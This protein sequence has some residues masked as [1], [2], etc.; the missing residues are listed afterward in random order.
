MRSNRFKHLSRRQL[1][2]TS[3]AVLIS[4]AIEWPRMLSAQATTEELVL[5]NGRIHTMDRN[6][7]I[8]NTVTMRNGRFTAVGGAMPRHAAGSSIIHLNRRDADPGLVA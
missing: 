2:K 7:A 8:V 6:N 5:M 1:L 3:A 4:S